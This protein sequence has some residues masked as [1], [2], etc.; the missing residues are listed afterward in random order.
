MLKRNSYDMS[1]DIFFAFKP[2]IP[3]VSIIENSSILTNERNSKI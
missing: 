2:G 3:T 1:N